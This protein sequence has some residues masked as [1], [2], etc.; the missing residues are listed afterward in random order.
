M[1]G[2]TEL[3]LSF[4]ILSLKSNFYHGAIKKFDTIKPYSYSGGH[5]LRKESWAVFLWHQYQLAYQWG[6]FLAVETITCDLKCNYPVFRYERLGLDNFNMKIGVKVSEIK[7]IE[8]KIEQS[9]VYF[10]VYTTKVSLTDPKL[11]FGNT[12]TQPEYT[13]DGNLKPLKTEKILLT[14]ENFNQ[15]VYGLDDINYNDWFRN[16]PN[17]KGIFAPIYNKGSL[18]KWGYISDEINAGRIKP[19]DDLDEI[20]KRYESENQ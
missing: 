2:N 4:K 8:E 17:M 3:D 10:Y 13:Y 12:H 19:G 9:E 6:L 11:G 1:L 20:T 5:K 16:R 18:H 15:Y 14:P 7:Q